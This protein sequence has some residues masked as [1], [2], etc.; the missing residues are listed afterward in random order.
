MPPDPATAARPL[1]FGSQMFVGRFA[2]EAFSGF[3][4]DY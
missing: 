3:N 1:M 2:S 4:P